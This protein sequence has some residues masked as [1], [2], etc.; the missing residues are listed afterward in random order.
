MGQGDA[1]YKCMFGVLEPY[2]TIDEATG[3]NGLGATFPKD[4]RRSFS[5][6]IELNAPPP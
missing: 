5:E 3:P 2:A 6:T 4:H 1:A